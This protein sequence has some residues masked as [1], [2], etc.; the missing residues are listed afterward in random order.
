MTTVKNEIFIGL[1]PENF[2]LMG[3]GISL[4]WGGRG[5]GSLLGGNWANIWLVGGLFPIPP[6]GK[7][8]KGESEIWKNNE[9]RK[10]VVSKE[11]YIK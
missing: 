9:K 3:E 11:I 1:Q 5:G 7:T 10:W 8:L 4:W 6:V 2:Y